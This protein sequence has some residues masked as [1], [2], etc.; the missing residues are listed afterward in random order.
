MKNQTKSYLTRAGWALAALSL[1]AAVAAQPD[2]VAQIGATEVKVEDIRPYLDSL[3]AREQGALSRDPALLNQ[4]VRSVIV[5]QLLL[6]EALA[7]RW[8]QQPASE[9]QLERVRQ[10]AIAEGYL[11]TVA[12]APEGFPSEAELKAAYESNK[13]SFLVP[14]QLQLAQ[15]FI[16]A[17]KNA[18]KSEIDKAQAKVEAV[19]GGLKQPNADFAALARVNS[20]EQQSAARNGEI[21]WLPESQIQPEVRA[22]VLALSKGAVS[23]PIRL[24]DGWHILKVLDIKEPYTPSLE[25][26]KEPLAQ[27]LRA[28]RAKANSEAYIARLLQQNPVAIN[29]IA[30]SKLFG[31]DGQ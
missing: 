2:P 8:D 7:A 28:A 4:F 9:A 18:D 12:K 15:I 21:G 20:E 26:I 3:N 22:Q 17:P 5:Q 16:A 29:E 14:R 30:L 23:E 19:R 10:N 6:K 24:G 27:Q 13:A 1:N 25:D 31:K 11:Q